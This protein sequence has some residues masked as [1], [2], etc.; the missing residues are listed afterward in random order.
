M[1][2]SFKIFLLKWIEIYQVYPKCSRKD[3]NGDAMQSIGTL[4]LWGLVVLL[5]EVPTW[6]YKDKHIQLL[7][8]EWE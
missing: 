3:V 5:F 2:I 6:L 1:V 8:I 7:F 4:I